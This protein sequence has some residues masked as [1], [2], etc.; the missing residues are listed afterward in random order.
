MARATYGDS[1]RLAKHLAHAGVASRRA[2]EQLI[3][4]GRVTVDGETVTDPARDVDGGERIT[5]DGERVGRMP[6]GP[7]RLCR[8]TS[9]PGS[10]RPRATRT[11]ARPSSTSCAL[12]GTAGC[13]RSDG[14]TPTAPA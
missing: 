3:A 8:C 9:P 1:V 10:S 4:A 6:A 2:A 13:I 12:R 5:V 14:S 7:R 11:G